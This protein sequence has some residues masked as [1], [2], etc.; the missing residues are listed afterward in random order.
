MSLRMIVSMVNK[1]LYKTAKILTFSVVLVFTRVTIVS[2]K[3]LS[4]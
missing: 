4:N 2:A 3:D 1:E